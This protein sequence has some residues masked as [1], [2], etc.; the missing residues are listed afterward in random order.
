MNRKE[1]FLVVIIFLLASLIDVT[2]DQNT[3]IITAIPTI[4][5]IYLSP[6]YLAVNIIIDVRSKISEL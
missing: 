5:I 4:G 2:A 3:P 1:Y 6:I